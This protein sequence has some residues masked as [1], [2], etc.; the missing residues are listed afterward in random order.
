MLKRNG[1]IRN[2][3]IVGKVEWFNKEKN[4]FNPQQKEWMKSSLIPTSDKYILVLKERR[5]LMSFSK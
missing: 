3:R 4:W 2:K 1:S 5:N